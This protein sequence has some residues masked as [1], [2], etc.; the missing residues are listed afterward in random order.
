MYFLILYIFAC[1]IP[2]PQAFNFF[3]DGEPPGRSLFVR[4]AFYDLLQYFIR[5]IDFYI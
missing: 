2:P 3:A 5:I 4:L 1:P